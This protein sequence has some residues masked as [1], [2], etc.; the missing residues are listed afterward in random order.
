MG[1][2]N[3]L[4][5]FYVL[6]SCSLVLTVACST[7]YLLSQQTLQSTLGRPGNNFSPSVNHFLYTLSYRPFVDL[8]MPRI[9]SVY[10]VLLLR[11][12]F[13]LLSISCSLHPIFP[14]IPPLIFSTGYK[15][16][17]LIYVH[18]FLTYDYT[19]FRTTSTDF[20]FNIL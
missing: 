10:D 6:C 9:S 13:R 5:K 15:S 18:E 20:I 11:V 7:Y 1:S 4:G 3:L 16:V 12:L 19:S 17:R 14:S 2:A 8:S